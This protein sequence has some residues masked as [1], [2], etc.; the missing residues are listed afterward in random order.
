[1]RDLKD[2]QKPHHNVHPPHHPHIFSS[3]FRNQQV[4]TDLMNKFI[5]HKKAN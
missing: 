1:M 5:E 3:F 4:L 2:Q